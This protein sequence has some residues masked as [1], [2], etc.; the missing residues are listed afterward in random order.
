MGVSGFP[1]PWE[2]AQNTKEHAMAYSFSLSISLETKDLC[3]SDFPIK[4]NPSSEAAFPKLPMHLSL[5][6]CPTLI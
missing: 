6:I 5:F 4:K 1:L 3:P 2:R